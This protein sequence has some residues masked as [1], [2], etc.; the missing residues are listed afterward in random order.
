MQ[1]FHDNCSAEPIIQNLFLHFFQEK[2]V[3]G[4]GGPL[5]ASLVFTLW[6]TM[7]G[8]CAYPAPYFLYNNYYTN[9]SLLIVAVPIIHFSS[10]SYI[11]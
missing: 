6:H 2:S 7:L 5:A 11:Y 10:S 1:V 9:L 4:G 8:M 3:G